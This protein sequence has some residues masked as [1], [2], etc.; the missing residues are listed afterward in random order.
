[1]NDRIELT[2]NTFSAIS[3]LNEG[4]PG[5]LSV[6]VSLLK[7]ME[8]IDPDNAFGGLGG[9]L[10]LDSN[11]VYGSRIWMFYKDFCKESIAVVIMMLRARQLGIIT[12]NQLNTA[13]DNYG[14]GI[15]ID[16]VAI[17]VKEQLPNFNLLGHTYND[18][19][20]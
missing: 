15:D 4:N 20:I 7:D 17:K 2:D 13:I 10:S 14:A 5:A 19:R 16:N 9:L 12:S 6:C 18:W 11:R 1:M 3:K 8:H